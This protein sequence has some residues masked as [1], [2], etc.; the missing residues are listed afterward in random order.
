[1]PANFLDDTSATTTTTK[2]SDAIRQAVEESV[3]SKGKVDQTDYSKG[4]VTAA[5]DIVFPSAASK[6]WN[7]IGDGAF[8]KTTPEP[9]GWD[10]MTPDQKKA[11]EEK[12]TEDDMNAFS[13]HVGGYN[14]D[15]NSGEYFWVGYAG[16]EPKGPP[17]P[18]GNHNYYQ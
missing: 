15:P 2:N 10:K 6:G 16:D 11:Y 13:W 18:G 12:Q 17:P 3:K 5:G 9:K 1:L 8:E 7:R 14:K 4:G